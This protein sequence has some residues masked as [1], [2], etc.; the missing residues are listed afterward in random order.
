MIDNIAF[1]LIFAL[2]CWTGVEAIKSMIS[3][4]RFDRENEK[5]LEEN[6]EEGGDE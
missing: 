2:L 3:L 1:T 6:K 4:I 5:W